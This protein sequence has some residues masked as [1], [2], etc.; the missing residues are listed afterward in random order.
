M[1]FAGPVYERPGAR[2]FAAEVG[3]PSHLTVGIV[4]E[5]K[6]ILEAARYDAMKAA[7][8]DVSRFHRQGLI[9]TAGLGS[10][11]RPRAKSPSADPMTMNRQQRRAAMR[12]AG[13]TWAQAR[14]NAKV[15]E[16][17]AENE[18]AVAAAAAKLTPEQARQ[19]LA[20][21]AARGGK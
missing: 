13:Y 6:A 1:A 16:R 20:E 3:R 19:A 4:M 15:R 9:P 18:R 8:D 2:P 21:W 11:G 12:K 17:S 14:R 10:T 7:G 5:F